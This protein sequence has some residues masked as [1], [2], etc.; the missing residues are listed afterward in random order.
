M[1]AKKR[2]KEIRE[3]I[4]KQLELVKKLKQKKQEERESLELKMKGKGAQGKISSHS[5]KHDK[6]MP[7]HHGNR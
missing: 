7:G 6:F 4:K 1:P 3:R 5:E 2:E